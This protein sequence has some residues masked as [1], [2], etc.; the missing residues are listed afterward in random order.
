MIKNNT[1]F[2]AQAPPKNNDINRVFVTLKQDN[3]LYSFFNIY[4]S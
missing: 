1:P 2:T 3:E 4:I